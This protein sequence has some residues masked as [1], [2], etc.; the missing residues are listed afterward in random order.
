MSSANYYAQNV[1]INCPFDKDYIKLRNALIF[2]VFD[3]GFIPRCALEEDDSGNVR[4][5]KI[6]RLIAESKY[7][8]HDLSRTSLDA[9]SSLPR[10]NMPFE[11]G[12][13]I[14]AKFF[15]RGKQKEK[16]CLIVD[17]EKYRYQ[18]YIS[19]IAGNDIRA[20]GDD[21]GE[22]ITQV[23]NWLSASLKNKVK[24]PGGKKIADRFKQF[25]LVLPEMCKALSYD[26]EDL[27]YN[28]YCQLISEW[29]EKN[30]YFTST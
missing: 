26:V 2:A 25:N 14:G 7:G 1:F 19:D 29:L 8:V 17:S 13:F 3:C 30:K 27:I 18:A 24:I 20:H 16:V 23:R 21:Q 11:L 5:N 6:Q 28:D 9:A 22:L 4:A 12:F 15:G 10:F